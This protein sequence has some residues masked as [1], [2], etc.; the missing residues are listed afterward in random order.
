MIR[1]VWSFLAFAVDGFAMMAWARSGGS[2]SAPS[3]GCT[4]SNIRASAPRY[5]PPSL[6]LLEIACKIIL[7]RL[8]RK[9]F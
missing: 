3:P 4:S 6:K 2:S 9:S 5:E 1:A 8:Q 7:L